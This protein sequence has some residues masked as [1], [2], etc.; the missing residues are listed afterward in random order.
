[1]KAD[2]NRIRPG[3]NTV[4]DL[5]SNL[6][7]RIYPFRVGL[8]R[9]MVVGGT[10]ALHR[11]GL[12]ISLSDGEVTGW[13]EASP[14]PGWS[15]STLEETTAALRQAVRTLGE[16]LDD[17]EIE[18]LI[19]HLEPH[20]A[21]ALAGASTDYLAQHEGRPLA[22]RLVAE[23]LGASAA[24]ARAS[25]QAPPTVRVNALGTAATRG[26][27]VFKLKVGARSP[28]ADIKRVRRARARLGPN[29]ELRLDANGAWDVE[30][31]LEVLWRV[32]DYD[33]A[34]CEE[35]VS[36]IEQLAALREIS[37]VAVAADESI[38][39]PADA[40]RALSL[41]ISVIIAK[42]SALGGAGV[43]LNIAQWALGAAATV[44]VTS[45]LDSAVGLTHALHTAAAVDALS[46]VSPA[47]GLATATKLATDVA[48]TPPVIDG[49]MALPT[50][51]GL[52]VQPFIRN[53]TH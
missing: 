48:D 49:R 23:R 21:A 13:G 17:S 37:P 46:P 51:P 40:R 32:E 18:E 41:G 15:K 42:P 30:T 6:Q 35:P 4:C 36:G 45:L 44:I 8:R 9:P 33:I 28:E 26:F 24:Q 19:R 5:A 27:D 1:M 22:E 43:V 2:Q 39:S 53:S 11:E 29:V 3:R 25:A 12:L 38:R 47:H 16:P 10:T 34:Y 50:T 31:A 14:L 52:G 7:Y 20:A